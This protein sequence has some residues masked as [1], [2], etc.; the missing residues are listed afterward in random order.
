MTNYK[1]FY[2][3]DKMRE[4]EHRLANKYG[5]IRFDWEIVSLRKGIGYRLWRKRLY[6]F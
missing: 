6:T 3:L 4:Y 1:D 2:D 5:A